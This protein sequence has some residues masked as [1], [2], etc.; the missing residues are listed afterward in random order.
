M[1]APSG[2]EGGRCVCTRATALPFFGERKGLN[3]RARCSGR[4]QRAPS[5]RNSGGA[6]TSVRACARTG[7]EELKLWLPKVARR[8]Y[9]ESGPCL[10]SD[11]ATFPPASI[12]VVRSRRRVLAKSFA[13]NLLDAMDRRSIATCYALATL[14]ALTGSPAAA[15]RNY[16]TPGKCA[17]RSAPR[18]ELAGPG[19]SDECH[20]PVKE[21]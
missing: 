1:G 4:G 9:C 8:V 5:P 19:T 15:W 6:R 16:G 7:S 20:R 14:L 21:L 3:A 17:A 2:L 10:R 11:D 18:H 13:P 12:S